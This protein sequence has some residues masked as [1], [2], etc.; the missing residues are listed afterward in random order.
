MSAPA[1][2]AQAPAAPAAAAPAVHNWHPVTTMQSEVYDHGTWRLGKANPNVLYCQ[3]DAAV[4]ATVLNSLQQ[5]LQNPD[6]PAGELFTLGPRR[7]VNNAAGTIS[8][9]VS[10]TD[11]ALQRRFDAVLDAVGVELWA[12][13]PAIEDGPSSIADSGIRLLPAF[14]SAVLMGTPGADYVNLQVGFDVAAKR[15][16]GSRKRIYTRHRKAMLT[17]I[18]I[19][20]GEPA[21]ENAEEIA[22]R[23]ISRARECAAA[24]LAEQHAQ[25]MLVPTEEFKR[26]AQVVSDAGEEEELAFE[27][28]EEDFETK[29]T[30]A[31]RKKREMKEFKTRLT[32][33]QRDEQRK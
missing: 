5:Q 3:T 15:F 19:T 1:Q 18:H 7:L 6:A 11:E 20:V 21:R 24:W 25:E 14:N 33:S 31:V 10:F 22:E 26:L 30:R 23:L 12:R 2:P 27:F 13:N 9:L 29:E 17:R 32:K 8:A 4:S 28:V 16:D